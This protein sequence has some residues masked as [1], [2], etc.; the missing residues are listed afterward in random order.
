MKRTEVKAVV[1]EDVT[2]DVM[3]GVTDRNAHTFYSG[4]LFTIHPS[5]TPYPGPGL[6][7]KV[8]VNK[9]FLYVEN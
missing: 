3:F 2:S 5:S 8:I 4:D 6:V 1:D 7:N 9:K